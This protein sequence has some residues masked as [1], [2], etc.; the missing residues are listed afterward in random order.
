[1][2]EFLFL[3][4][5]TPFD[6]REWPWSMVSLKQKWPYINFTLTLESIELI[7]PYNWIFFNIK[8][9]F[10]SIENVAR[11]PSPQPTIN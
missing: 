11:L 6:Y 5:F 2:K 8:N 7:Y 4:S 3:N 1:M 10:Y 9:L